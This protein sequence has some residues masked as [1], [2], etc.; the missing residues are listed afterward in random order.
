MASNQRV[1]E[2]PAFQRASGRRKALWGKAPARG[3]HSIFFWPKTRLWSAIGRQ[4][5]D[6]RG[7]HADAHGAVGVMIEDL[8]QAFKKDR[9]LVEFLD[10]HGG[11]D[12][13]AGDV[14][15]GDGGI[16]CHVRR[17]IFAGY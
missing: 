8:V 1:S 2:M 5:R 7:Y 14:D 16:T 15:C 3:S 6:R 11:L 10:Q 4:H 9:R 13:E 12:L 17:T